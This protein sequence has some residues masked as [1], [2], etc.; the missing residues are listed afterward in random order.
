MIT[1]RNTVIT[2]VT[3][4]IEEDK[5]AITFYFSGIE[6]ESKCFYMGGYEEPKNVEQTLKLFNKTHLEELEGEEAT[7]VFDKKENIVAISKRNGDQYVLIPDEYYSCGI[8]TEEGVI[9]WLKK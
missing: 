7:L 2:K 6:R 8:V 5:L 9:E 1:K 4:G 3:C